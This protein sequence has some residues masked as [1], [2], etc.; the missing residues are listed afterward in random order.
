MPPPPVPPVL[1]LRTAHR[2]SQA[3][4]KYCLGNQVVLFYEIRVKRGD[5]LS[6]QKTTKIYMCTNA[7]EDKERIIFKCANGH[8]CK[9]ATNC[10]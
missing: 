1:Y 5:D 10:Y 7:T 9:N 3:T 8:D 6:L 2:G 4:P